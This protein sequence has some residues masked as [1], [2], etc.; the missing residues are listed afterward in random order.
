MNVDS[1]KENRVR[2]A[3]AAVCGALVLSALSCTHKA[4]KVE[5]VDWKVYVSYLGYTFDWQSEWYT[6]YWQEKCS[7][8]VTNKG[9]KIAFEVRVKANFDY[10]MTPDGHPTQQGATGSALISGVN[11]EPGEVG[12]FVVVG[13]TISWRTPGY[14]PADPSVT[15]LLVSVSWE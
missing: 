14:Q 4:A 2:S 13:D 11:L 15:A 6:W 5:V 12:Q 9:D 8:R 7:G 1:V 3:L 10:F